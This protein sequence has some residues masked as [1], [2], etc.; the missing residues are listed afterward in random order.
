V[1]FVTLGT[2]HQ[3]FTRLTDALA[4]LPA[5]ELVVQHGHSPAPAGVRE[6]IAFLDFGSMLERVREADVVVTHAGVGSILLARREGHTPVVVPRLHR[7]GEHVD[8]HQVELTEALAGDGKVIAVWEPAE[9]AAAVAAAPGRGDR[10]PLAAGPLHAAV[11]E[12][13]LAR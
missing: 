9:L 13:L 3:P 6:A 4:A 8:D 12:A 11:R 7:H 10:R 2:H 5:D 1:I